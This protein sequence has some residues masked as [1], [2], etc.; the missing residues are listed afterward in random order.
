MTTTLGPTELRAAARVLSSPAL[1]RLITEID[2]NGPIPPRMLTATLPDLTR[3]SARRAVHIARAHGLVQAGPAGGLDLTDSGC[4]L[5]AFYDA[6]A[7]WARHHAYPGPVSTFTTRIQHT[8]D[9]LI[10]V[11]ATDSAAGHHRHPGTDMPNGQ[12][13]EED[14]P[15]HLIRW[16]TD[17]PHLTQPGTQHGLAA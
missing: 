15:G 9:L 1:I 17:N 4:H 5:A 11:L 16:L 14:L 2:D 10:H 7:R 6:T 12:D 3:S 8:L 13:T